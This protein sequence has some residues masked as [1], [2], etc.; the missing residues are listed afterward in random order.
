ME[1]IKKLIN[2]DDVKQELTNK[3]LKNILNIA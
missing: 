2:T 3:E 1:E